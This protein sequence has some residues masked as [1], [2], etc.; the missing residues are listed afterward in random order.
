MVG[1][2]CNNGHR[3]LANEEDGATLAQLTSEERE[4]IGRKGW[5]KSADSDADG[6]GKKNVFRF[7]AVE[8]L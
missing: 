6:K 7:D 3:F 2:L 8:K 1:R 4:P 5:V